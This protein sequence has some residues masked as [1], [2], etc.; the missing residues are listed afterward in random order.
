T[1][2]GFIVARYDLPDPAAATLLAGSEPVRETLTRQNVSSAPQLVGRQ[3]LAVGVSPV[4]AGNRFVGVV[5]ASV[6]LDD[7]YLAQRAFTEPNLHL[8]IVG[9]DGQ[10]AA[11]GRRSP[12]VSGVATIGL[13]ALRDAA[14]A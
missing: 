5:V 4:K 12:P 13:R 14:P 11:T 10:L 3:P 9:R 1:D 8:A 6:L 2:R 7:K